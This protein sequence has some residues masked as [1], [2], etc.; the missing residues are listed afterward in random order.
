MFAGGRRA[1]PAA[2]CAPTAASLDLMEERDE[3]D[4]PTSSERL[5]ASGI[6]SAAVR[7][8]AR[9][10]GTG[11]L[12]RAAGAAVLRA[13]RTR[14]A[15]GHRWLPADDIDGEDGAGALPRGLERLRA[16]AARSPIPRPLRQEFDEL[17]VGVGKPQVMPYAL[18][19][20]WR[21]S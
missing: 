11:R 14:A 21:A 4:D 12:L 13:R 19:T 20:T 16:A 17:F 18:A 2:R 1:R 9:G 15:A 5:S 3:L 7:H 8:R 10:R 6:A